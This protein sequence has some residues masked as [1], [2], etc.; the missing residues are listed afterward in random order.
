MGWVDEVIDR[1]FNRTARALRESIPGMAYNG[2]PEKLSEVEGVNPVRILEAEDD[3]PLHWAGVHATNYDPET[4]NIQLGI[5]KRNPRQ[6]GHSFEIYELEPETLEDKGLEDIDPE[7]TIRTENFANGEIESVEGGALRQKDDE[8]WQLL[9]SYNGSEGWEIARCGGEEISDLT[10]EGDLPLDSNY[11]HQKDPVILGDEL[12]IASSSG[13]WLD[14]GVESVDLDGIDE[15]Y[16]EAIEAGE[17]DPIETREYEVN[18]GAHVRVTGGGVLGT[19]AFVDEKPEVPLLGWTN[20]LWNQDERSRPA[21]IDDGEDKIRV[22]ET[23]YFQSEC[24]DSLRYLHTL[25]AK[26]RVYLFWEEEQPDQ[27]HDAYM[28]VIDRDDYSQLLE[29]FT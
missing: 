29:E 9:L 28:A 18:G 12:F 16:K 24:G 19:E 4:G 3:S 2:E 26:D 8:D 23:T 10:Y 25:E 14:G 17:A 11:T 22:D 7:E 20:L 27:S 21:E 1:A 13:S 15:A 5:R 6:R